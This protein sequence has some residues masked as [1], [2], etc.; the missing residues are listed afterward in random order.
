MGFLYRLRDVDGRPPVLV[1]RG[2]ISKIF[3]LKETR[4]K[5][6]DTGTT[7]IKGLSLCLLG[8]K[9]TVVRAPPKANVF[10]PENDFAHGKFYYVNVPQMA[11]YTASQP[12]LIEQTFG[13]P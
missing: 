8:R 4:P 11:E 12:L 6:V 1:N 10:T 3:A 5:S 7:I 9:L 2:W 13:I